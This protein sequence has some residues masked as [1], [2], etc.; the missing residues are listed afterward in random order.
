LIVVLI[1]GRP[2][3]LGDVLDTSDAMV[4]A[5]LPGSEGQGVADVLFGDS[6]PAGKL[7]F[8]WPRTVDQHPINVNDEDY[9]PLFEFGYGLTYGDDAAAGR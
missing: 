6:A 1:S 4:A 9:D 8:T 7:S 5:W 3:I 2:M